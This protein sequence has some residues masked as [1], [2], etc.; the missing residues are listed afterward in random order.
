[1]PFYIPNT[2]VKVLLTLIVTLKGGYA[3]NFNLTNLEVKIILQEYSLIKGTN[4]K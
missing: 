1:M 3:D 2:K 4:C